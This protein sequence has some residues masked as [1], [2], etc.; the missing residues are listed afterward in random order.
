MENNNLL[1]TNK[2]NGFLNKIKM[3]FKSIFNKSV[4]LVET[5]DKKVEQIN[6]KSQNNF[7]QNLKQD[8]DID[9]LPVEEIVKNIEENPEILNTLTIEQLENVNEYYAKQIEKVE[10]EIN[11]LKKHN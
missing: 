10:Q 6:N 5:T 8:T 2:A 11:R 3:F 4:E 9:N 1:P 7:L